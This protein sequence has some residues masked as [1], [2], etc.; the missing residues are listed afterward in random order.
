RPADALRFAERT[1][2]ALESEP[3]RAVHPEVERLRVRIGIHCGSPSVYPAKDGGQDYRG[4]DVGKAARVM[5]T[6][7]GGTVVIS[8]EA[9]DL[10]QSGPDA[11]PPVSHFH[12]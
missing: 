12:D 4:H 8:G 3:W 7:H 5:D 9:H 6:A 2:R 10:L 11:P 1:L